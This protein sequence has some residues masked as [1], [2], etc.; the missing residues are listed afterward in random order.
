MLNLLPREGTLLTM[1]LMRELSNALSFTEQEIAE[2]RIQEQEGR[3]IW[4]GKPHTKEVPIGETMRGIVEVQLR[5]IDKSG[6]M[7]LDTLELAEKFGY[8]GSDADN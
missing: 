2:C 6:T 7:T 3:V 8:G 5:Q 4:D 1:R